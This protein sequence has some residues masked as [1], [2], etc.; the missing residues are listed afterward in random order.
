MAATTGI[1]AGA[2]TSDTRL[3]F[4]K[5]TAWATTPDKPAFTNLRLTSE[6]MQWAKE[7]V[8]SNEIRPDRN[9]VDEIQ[10]S[11][12]SAGNVD[13]ELSYGAFDDLIESAMFSEWATN[14]IKN[15]ADAGHSFTVERRLALP[16]ASYE[17]H[18][19]IGQVVNTMSLNV[20]AGQI[21]TG[22]FGLMGK[23]GG[24]DTAII[25]DATYADAPQNEVINAAN[26]FASLS[27]G[28]VAPVPLVR[29]VSLEIT[30]NLRAQQAVGSLDAVGIGAG[31]FEATG[32]MECYFTSGDLITSFLN[33]E[34]IALSF[35]LGTATAK[36]Y[37]FTLP[38]IVLTGNPGA[39]AGGNDQDVMLTLSFTAILDRLTSTGCALQ[40]ERA[41]A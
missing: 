32:S 30:N 12:S 3:A 37:K 4:V 8:R 25:E 23:F 22:S 35:V 2:N 28:A 9:I 15:G 27:V 16:D 24:R 39:N 5:E 19:F 38:S 13:F 34:T 29:S 14:K 17:Y 10:V 31:R 36:K 40:I 20:T 7:T 21:V 6:N 33:H 1:R 26:H 11:R 41:V 18:R